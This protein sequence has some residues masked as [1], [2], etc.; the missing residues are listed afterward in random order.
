MNRWGLYLLWGL[1]GFCLSMGILVHRA[2][3]EP[4]KEP[5]LSEVVKWKPDR[6]LGL[7][8]MYHIE[9]QDVIFAHPVKSQGQ[10]PACKELQRSNY[11]EIHV[12]L[13]GPNPWIY[14]VTEEA[15]MYKIGNSV[16]WEPTGNL[17]QTVWLNPYQFIVKE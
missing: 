7:L 1:I 15:S 9:G 8:L 17:K 12:I 4:I 3:G 10:H 16:Q 11:G 5:P 14:I 6:S 2:N 13:G